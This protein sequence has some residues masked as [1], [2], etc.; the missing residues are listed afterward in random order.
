LLGW[1]LQLLL[2]RLLLLGKLVRRCD[3]LVV[4]R[5][6]NRSHMRILRSIRMR[7]GRGGVW[8]GCAR[9]NR[10]EGCARCRL[11]SLRCYWRLSG[12]GLRGL[13]VFLTLL[14]SL[15]FPSSRRLLDF[16]LLHVELLPL[17][18]QLNAQ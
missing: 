13:G 9:P 7:L 1:R 14:T 11:L 2:G 3:T 5:S 18:N 8:K 12:T 6:A 4:N 15:Q 17:R 10:T 16:N